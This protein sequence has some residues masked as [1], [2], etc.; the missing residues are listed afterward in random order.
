[1]KR[2]IAIAAVLLL[3]S[4][5]FADKAELQRHTVMS[6]GHPIAL[7][8]KRAANARQ[9]VLLVHGRTWS[10]L[11]DFDLQV[12]GEDLSLM[13][14]L[15]DEGY[16][17]FAVDLRG[18]GET[19]RDESG[20]LT[21]NRAADDVAAVIDWIAAKDDWQT[22]PHLFGWSMGSTISQLMVQ[23]HPGKVASLTLFG[24][25]RDVDATIPADEPGIRPK[26]EKNTAEAAA[27]DFITPGSISRKAI[28]TYVAAA[29]EADPVKV[30]LRA[31]DQYNAL[32]GSKIDVPTLVIAG[33]HD[34]LA[35]AANQGQL[36]LSIATGH[37]QYVSVP[38]GDHA[39]FLETPR[40]Y[41][42]R[43]LV[44]FFESALLWNP[45]AA[46][47]VPSSV[48]GMFVAARRVRNPYIGARPTTLAF[49]STA[50]TALARIQ[51]PWN[52]FSN[53]SETPR[54]ARN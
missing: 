48:G 4:T 7:W 22:K 32:D 18:Y 21:P 51:R 42:I 47:A 44:A 31:Y 13:D 38:G 2:T 49:R 40:A 45:V 27:S 16:V 19:P 26:R 41:F 24:Y 5:V 1:M 39:A 37:K 43:E 10:A 35:P 54:W 23:R 28:D 6:D 25:W 11:P 14:G 3:A 9:A 8:E 29:L 33:E 46:R 36:F 15:V 20:W 34:P 53:C 52:R 17:V 50:T 12:D 30:D